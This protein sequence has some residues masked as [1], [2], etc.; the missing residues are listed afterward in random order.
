MYKEP[1]YLLH[2]EFICLNQDPLEN[3][4]KK[5]LE[6]S[7]SKLLLELEVKRETVP[8]LPLPLHINSVAG[9][10]REWLWWYNPST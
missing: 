3:R 1:I 6:E 8:I 7:R 2:V 10:R 4:G 5:E 9:R